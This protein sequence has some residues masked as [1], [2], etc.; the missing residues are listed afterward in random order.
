MTDLDPRALARA[1]R[2]LSDADLAAL[3]DDL[4]FCGFTGVPSARIVEVLT[5]SLVISFGRRVSMA[6]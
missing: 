1:L 2:S 3:E 6:A 5:D 4:D